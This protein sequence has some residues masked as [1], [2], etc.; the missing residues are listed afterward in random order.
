[1]TRASKAVLIDGLAEAISTFALPSLDALFWSE[2][3][4]YIRKATGRREER[5]ATMTTGSSRWPAAP[6]SRNS[7]ATALLARPRPRRTYYRWSAERDNMR[8]HDG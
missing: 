4:T 1:M 2:A 5:P 3:Q 6:G 7:Q 8:G